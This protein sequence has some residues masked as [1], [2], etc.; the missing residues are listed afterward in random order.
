MNEE[1]R[2]DI[3]SFVSENTEAVFRDIARLVAVDSVEGSPAPGAPFGEGPRKALDLGLQIARELGLGAVDCEGKLGY[4]YVGE[5]CDRYLATI[6]HLDVVPVG[7]G[8]TKEPFGGEL[9]GNRLYGRGTT[10]DKGPAVAALHAMR[11]VKEAGIPLKD[12]VKL[13]LGCDEETGMQDMVYYKKKFGSADYGF[14]PD[15]DFPVINIEKGGLV[16]DR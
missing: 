10:D 6:T 4:A 16:C 15:A 11:A 2:R 7:D 13:I 14:S 8:W 3:E 12:G 5:D 9:V 1:L